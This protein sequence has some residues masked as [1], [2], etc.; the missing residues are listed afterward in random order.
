MS[1][2]QTVSN[3]PNPSTLEVALQ[4]GLENCARCGNDHSEPLDW[5]A[6]VNP[7]PTDK[8]EY[9]YWA[10]CPTNGDPILLYVEQIIEH[11]YKDS[12]LQPNTCGVDDCGRPPDEHRFFDDP[13][14]PL[15]DPHDR[16]G[17]HEAES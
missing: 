2:E 15:Q 16:M 13:A 3:E 6:F 17:L 14:G 5:H 4:S 1:A 12:K 10:S 9:R 11:S 8:G 7:V